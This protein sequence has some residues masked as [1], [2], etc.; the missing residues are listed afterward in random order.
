MTDAQDGT[1]AVETTDAA[2]VVDATA[3]VVAEE[4]DVEETDADDVISEE[5]QPKK[6]GRAKGGARRGRTTP[7]QSARPDVS[8]LSYEEA[9]DKLVETVSRLESGQADLEA[10]V[11]LWELGEA[12]AAHCTA[13]LD[14]AEA[15]LDRARDAQD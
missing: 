3:E 5:A 12:L 7:Q 15:R 2:V 10:S 14:R 4:T 9:R 11:A 13:A 8:H 1:D 6:A